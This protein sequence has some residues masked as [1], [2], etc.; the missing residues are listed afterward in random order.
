MQKMTILS[1]ELNSGPDIY[2]QSHDH[3]EDD[4]V[5]GVVVAVV[6]PVDVSGVETHPSNPGNRQ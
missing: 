5:D 6:V 1:F 3:G 2:R 4:D